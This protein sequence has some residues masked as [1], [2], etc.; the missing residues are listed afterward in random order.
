M[1]WF[2]GL[3]S[4]TAPAP[5]FA[6]G[7]LS[8][9]VH[10]TRKSKKSSSSKKTMNLSSSPTSNDSM[11]GFASRAKKHATLTDT[12]GSERTKDRKKKKKNKTKIKERPSTSVD[13]GDLN[14]VLRQRA[15]PD[16]DDE[17]EGGGASG[18][19]IWD[20]SGEDFNVTKEDAAEL[21][22]ERESRHIGSPLVR[23]ASSAAILGVR[24]GGMSLSK[25]EKIMTTLLKQMSVDDSAA[26]M[27][28]RRASWGEDMG[29][30]GN[31]RA[32]LS[33]PQM[34]NRS[35]INGLLDMPRQTIEQRPMSASGKSRVSSAKLMRREN[36]DFQ[37]GRK[38]NK[39][40]GM[41]RRRENAV[42]RAAEAGNMNM[43]ASSSHGSSNGSS[44]N[45]QSMMNGKKKTNRPSSRKKPPAKNMF[46][47]DDIKLD[48]TRQ[49]ITEIKKSSPPRNGWGAPS[50]EEGQGGSGGEPEAGEAQADGGE[51]EEVVNA[52]IK[53]KNANSVIRSSGSPSNLSL[54]DPD[55]DI[56]FVLSPVPPTRVRE[57]DERRDNPERDGFAEIE[58][59]GLYE[60]KIEVQNEG[61]GGGSERVGH[62]GA[63]PMPPADRPDTVAGATAAVDHD[64]L[65]DGSSSEEEDEGGWDEKAFT[66]VSKKSRAEGGWTDDAE[67]DLMLTSYNGDE[68]DLETNLGTDFLNLFAPSPP[69]VGRFGSL[70]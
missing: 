30:L 31:Q 6:R 17:A 42:R 27:L 2:N 63:I 52:N 65:I 43:S 5:S 36:G 47:N 34:N 68:F 15:S 4:G 57:I 8:S 10:T 49:L 50:A 41:L 11:M 35:P 45:S 58:E 56:E 62:M 16:P 14:R 40:A 24:T 13:L 32:E 61:E 19:S 55:D 21:D 23:S 12:Y 1:D 9:P 28:Q 7:T 48:G 54:G 60:I 26:P 20:L 18:S 70:K 25:D 64:L 69:P 38:R 67:D 39:S 46:L 51:D 33:T 22:D 66:P 59:S 29:N 53:S 37:A 3:R 44:S